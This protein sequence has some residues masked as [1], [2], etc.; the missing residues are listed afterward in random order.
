LYYKAYDAP[1]FA[2]HL[3]E[4]S[5]EVTGGK[6][7][8]YAFTAC[9]LSSATDILKAMLQTV[10]ADCLGTGIRAGRTGKKLTFLL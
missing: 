9:G 4:F 8:G 1:N 2:A 5:A 6:S 10:E 3:K 7:S